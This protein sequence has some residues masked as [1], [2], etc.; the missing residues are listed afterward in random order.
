MITSEIY[1]ELIKVIPEERVS[2][3]E[4]DSYLGNIGK[5][6][7]APESEEEISNLLSYANENGKTISILSGGTKRGY[8]GT[9]ELSDITL[10][11]EKYKGIVEHTVGDMTLTVKAGTPFKEIQDYLAQYNQKISLDPSW[12]EDATVGGVVAA[13]DSGPKRLGYGSARDVVIGLRVVYPDGSVIRSGGKVVKNV[14]G[15]DMNKLFIGSMGTIG[16]IS[17]VTL[18]LRPIPKYESLV[19]L[20]FAD[21]KLNELKNFVV[22]LLDSMMEPVTLELLNPS[23]SE[24]MTSKN[25]YTLAIAFED[26]KN[27]VLYQEE[28]VKNMKPECGELQ[29]LEKEKAAVFWEAFYKIGPNGVKDLQKQET[30]ASLKIG[31][32]NLDGIKVIQQSELLKDTL[33]LKIEANSGLAHGIGQINLSGSTDD[34]EA[35][36]NQLRSFVTEL[37]GYVTVKHLPLSLRQK[38]SVWGEDPSY[39]FLLE[40]IKTKIDPNRILNPKRFVGGI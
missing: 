27:S 18:K 4:P 22:K 35:A 39:F 36:I 1:E 13:N 32:V 11:L 17:E 8:G 7:V 33:N 40:G 34:V 20:S 21:G 12:P 28:F 5:I 16:V 19:L 23:L 37:G 14:A 3:Q 31:V 29:I 25:N 2:N 30:E 9:T 10:S 15:Y 38:I 26:V 24:R 6:I